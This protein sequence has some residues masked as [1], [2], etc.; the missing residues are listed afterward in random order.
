MKLRVGQHVFGL[1]AIAFGVITLNWHQISSF[2]N[3]SNPAVLVYMAGILELI[4]GIAIQWQRTK[5]AG[6]LIIG[7][8]F[9]IFSLYWIPQIIK[10]P[11]SFGNYGNFFE[12]FSVVI[13][14]VYVYVSTMQSHREK[15]AK[16]VRVA[17]ISFG[18]CVLSYALYQLFYV[19]YTA[20]LVPRWIPPGQMFWEVATTIAFALAA[21]A[22]LSGI[23]AL[24]ASRLLT[25]MLIGFG[26]LIWLPACMMHPNVMNNWDENALNLAIAGLAWIVSDFLYQKNNSTGTFSRKATN[27]GR[28]RITF[29]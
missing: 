22:I 23:S 14:S 9:L 25:I 10:M 28:I 8:I 12:V 18:I 11:L 16:I 26:V 6:A 4:G 27:M 3:L 2:G 19:N 5:K 29:F 15:A 24:L 7:S 1:A 17:N 21:F 20:N 13:G